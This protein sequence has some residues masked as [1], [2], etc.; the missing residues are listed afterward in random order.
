[1]PADTILRT[2][3]LPDET[4]NYLAEIAAARGLFSRPDDPTSGLNRT[5]A[6]IV[7]AAEERARVSTPTQKKEKRR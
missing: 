7:V 2:F 5:A 3:R 4:W 1:M 6:I